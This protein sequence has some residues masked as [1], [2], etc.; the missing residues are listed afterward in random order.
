M[1]LLSVPVFI[2]LYLNWISKHVCSINSN[3]HHRH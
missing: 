2:V 3:T 1:K